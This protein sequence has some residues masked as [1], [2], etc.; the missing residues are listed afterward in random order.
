MMNKIYQISEELTSIVREKELEMS[1]II[2]DVPP[3]ILLLENGFID[4]KNIVSSFTFPSKR[5]EIMFFKE[6]KPQLFSKLI[7]FRKIYQLELNRPI[8][9]YKTIRVYLEREHE[10]INLFYNRNTEFIQYYR[11]G[12]A[13]FDEYY[14]VRG[15]KDMELN[16][17][18]FYFERDPRFS[19]HFDFKVARLLANDMLAAHLNYQLSKLKYQEENDFS[20]DI[21][22]PFAQWTDKKTALTEIIYGIYEEKSINSGNIEIKALATIFGRIFNVDLNDIYHI[23]LEIRSRKTNRTEFL[24]RLIKTLNKRMDEA[25]SK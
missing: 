1:D 20:T 25:D 5:D 2:R 21:E 16:L 14:F 13:N 12:K 8:S 17:E 18:S 7:F 9:N 4:L 22:I 24:N 11:S 19:T 6:I 10:R 23:Y 15:R 3:T